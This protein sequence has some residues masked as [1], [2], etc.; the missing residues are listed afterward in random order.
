MSS[1]PQEPMGQCYAQEVAEGQALRI[2]FVY[3]LTM[4]YYL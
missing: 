4:Y 2:A 1:G 3:Q